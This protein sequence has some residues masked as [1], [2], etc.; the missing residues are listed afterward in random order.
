MFKRLFMLFFVFLVAASMQA[1]AQQLNYQAIA[2]NAN[3]VA[4]TFRDVGIRLSIRDG[5]PVGSIVYSESRNIRT[6]QFGLFTVI[7]G[8]PGAS[9]VMGSMASIN[10]ISGNKY[11]QVEIDPEGGTNY[12]Q[13]GTSQLQ[14]VP[15][16]LFANAAYPVGPAGGDLLGSSYP[17]PIIAPLVITTGKI[18]NQAITTP[19]IADLNVTTAKLE[20]QAV[21]NPKIADNTIANIKLVN[22][23]VTLNGLV[24]NLGDVQDFA[25]GNNGTDVNIVS[26][27]N[28]HTFN[29]PDATSFSRGL[30]TTVAQTFGGNKTFNNDITATRIIRAGGIAAQ[31][32]K[33]DGSVD[34][35]IYLTENQ[36]IIVTAT[37]DATGVSTS[38]RTAP[39]LPLTLA[40]V[41]S[42]VGTYGTNLVIP[43]ITVN[44]KG[45][46]TNVVTNPIPT[47]TA[48]INGLLNTGDWNR[49]NNKQNA[50]SLGT[51]AQ[52][53]RGDLTLSNF[54][55]DV[56][57]QLSAGTN[58]TYNNGNIG[59]TNNSVTLN[60]LPLTLGGS[61][62][63]A[64][65]TTGVDFNIS[66][67]GSVHTFNIPTASVFARG[68]LSSSDYTN[69]NA[70][71]TNRISSL[72]TT[73]TSG[74]ATLSA[75]V[76]NIPNYTYTLPA[77]TATILGGI[78]SGANITNTS[79][80]ISVTSNN[81]INALGSQTA[82]RFLVAP[83]GSNGLPTFRAM[84]T[85]D[86]PDNIVTNIKLA[87]S[88][89]ILGTTNIPLGGT[90]NSLLG[91][92]SVTSGA[93]VGPLTG[94]AST[95]STWANARTISTT[96][97]VLY[98]SNPFDGSGNTTGVATLANSGVTP[99]SYGSAS[100]IPSFTVDAKGRINSATSFP[101]SGVS[102]LG[103]ALTNGNI[104]IGSAANIAA[105]VPVTG[106]V[107]LSNAGVTTIGALKVTDAMLAGGIT[108]GKLATISTPGK[109]SN[110]ATTATPLN[111]INTI[112]SRDGSGNFSAGTIT[113]NLTGNATTVTNGVYT[114][115]KIN[116]LS[117]TTS[118]EL[119]GIITDKTGTGS[120]VFGTSPTFVTPNLGTPA[121]GVATNLTGLPLTTGVTGV[122]PIANGG[123]GSATK[124]FVDLTTN[125]T[126]DG[127]KTFNSNIV[128]SITGNATTVTN[129]VYTTNKINVLSPTTSAE[130]A[131]I[132]TDKTGTGSLVFGTSPTF[133]TPN[134]GT[135]ASGVATNLTGL[136][137]TTGVT[138][139]L[140]IA[141]G[142]TGSAIK[143][144]VDL[145]SDQT[146]DGIKTFNSNIV[147][148]ITGNAATVTNGI[149]TT[150]KINALA[151][152]TSA[153]LAAVISDE[154]GTGALAFSTSPSF[155][156]PTLGA[157]TATSINKLTITAPATSATLTIA[158]GKTLTTNNSIAL[159][160][161]DGTIMT[162]PTTSA[163][164]A[165]TDAAQTFTGTQT[166]S[167]DILVN[168]IRVGRG[169]FD[170]AN[171]TAVGNNALANAAA[172]GL[173]NSAF[174]A[175]T[176][177]L[178]GSG[179][180]NTALGFGTLALNVSG[181][182]NTAIGQS[183]LA[184]TT[185]SSNTAVGQA[186]MQTNT[187]GIN[188][189]VMGK[190]ALFTNL[191]G[192]SNTAIGH[193]AARLTTGSRNTSLGQNSLKD[194]LSGE[195][196]IA[197]GYQALSNTTGSNN[198]GI[199]SNTSV[200]ATFQNSI[201]IGHGASSSH[202]A[203]VVLGSGASVTGENAVAIGVGASNADGNS[204]LLGGATNSLVKAT[205]ALTA[206]G[207]I[208]GTGARFAY[209]PVTGN[210]TL[211][212][213]HY[214]LKVTSSTAQ[215]TLPDATARPGQKYVIA[216]RTSPSTDIRTNILT[217]SSQT[218]TGFGWG[219]FSFDANFS[220]IIFSDGSN[221]IIES[222]FR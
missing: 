122:L 138:G 44:N 126:I 75:N 148:S 121:S 57:N 198:I 51:T 176:L 152:T 13:A 165:R 192:Q 22:S 32:L 164:I 63:F 183:A 73:G 185:G 132:I 115:N 48:T 217:T 119:A 153:E 26:A 160:G 33:A 99:G 215:I 21:T 89:I 14:A 10:W 208:T 123:T 188:N 140:P 23:R 2:R 98:T 159:S 67:V 58:I 197:I 68:L 28:T 155:V 190:D 117:P 103:S 109:V 45:L 82:N 102:T 120:L 64:T 49:F 173:R 210:I 71:F 125:Q 86:I 194:N 212:D 1:N 127:I 186:A 83:N 27:G 5:S 6:N 110:F 142:G 219:A 77:A 94:N 59:L 135:P 187:T 18:A 19:K 146:I 129:G 174:G 12:F 52:Y 41:N 199:G 78:I 24:L 175:G 81:V 97:D 56:R 177:A 46:V 171:N 118:A 200:A 133:V 170:N 20:D 50:I 207:R 169:A 43:S 36:P 100:S 158:D 206:T 76:L 178:N 196:N 151:A 15:Y 150:S 60:T 42:A 80:T 106:D 40:T 55:T 17:N 220:L 182:N 163:T 74:P 34:N 209:D 202:T 113:A 128:G 124:N 213:N 79:G 90:A 53:F 112:V 184:N 180:D 108:D 92:T 47:A 7:I 54:Q 96:G 147:G 141:N 30:V 4:L 65:G 131:G 189:T 37:G 70:A 69:F 114:T 29:F 134:L 38:S 168:S 154:T 181:S 66:S 104:I 111:I 144:F 161:T 105:Q 214:Y 136:P 193:F 88:N 31:F 203:T 179:D 195:D 93:F 8:S 25:V 156:T 205:G 211:S 87:N 137:L 218:I 166:F 101:I 84:A 116:V 9:N 145:T 201:V 162:F 39:V 222:P 3:G 95:A 172:T 191:S 35:N 72:T 62:T 167:A 61:Q 221:W 143:N 91:L 139:V 130:L 11:L 85:G 204:I 149:Y 157:A 107:T 16:A 216:N